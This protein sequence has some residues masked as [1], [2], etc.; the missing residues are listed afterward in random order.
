MI[1]TNFKK[2]ILTGL[3][4]LSTVVL[5]FNYK[6]LLAYFLI[7][8]GI[9]SIMEFSQMIIKIFSSKAKIFLSNLFFAIYVFL[10]CLLFFFFSNVIEL[11]FILLVLLAGCVASDIGG[12]FFGKIFKGPKLTKISPNK[13]Y[14]GVAGSLFFSLTTISFL[15]FNFIDTFNL[16]IVIIAFVTSVSCQL[17]DLFFSFVKRKAKV[18]DTGNVLPGHGG[19]LDRLD[20]IFLG[21][22]MGFLILLLIS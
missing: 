16:Y 11:K 20:G 18:K 1:S 19:V 12:Y 15:F 3:L 13:T 22:P 8:F 4:L 2:R 10:F 14:S 7:I 6:I 17:G 9:F 21:I 5:I